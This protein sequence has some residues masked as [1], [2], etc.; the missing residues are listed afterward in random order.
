M[1]LNKFFTCTTSDFSLFSTFISWLK[2]LLNI[3]SAVCDLSRFIRWLT[4]SSDLR[5]N[6]HRGKQQCCAMKKNGAISTHESL[7]LEIEWNVMVEKQK[8]TEKYSKNDALKMYFIKILLSLP[9]V[10]LFKFQLLDYLFQFLNSLYLLK[11]HANHCTYLKGWNICIIK[12]VATFFYNLHN[13]PQFIT[14][15]KR[16]NNKILTGMRVKK[17][18]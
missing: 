11:N 7:R 14:N 3:C 16:K 2:V 15:E 13:R 17:R 12:M 1:H 10:Y 18:E 5:H 9:F 6:R 8:E 4:V